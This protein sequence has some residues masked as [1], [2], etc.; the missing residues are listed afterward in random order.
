MLYQ[1][2]TAVLFSSLFKVAA[3]LKEKRESITVPY[4]A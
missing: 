1:A 4:P 2:E 3:K